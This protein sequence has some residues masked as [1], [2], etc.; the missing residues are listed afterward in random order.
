[1]GF[2]DLV[3]YY[4]NNK[5][6]NEINQFVFYKRKVY[7]FYYITLEYYFSLDVPKLSY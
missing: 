3:F 7:V 4:Y 6:I 5:A 2:N 1:M